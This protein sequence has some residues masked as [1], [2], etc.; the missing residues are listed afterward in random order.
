MS[1]ANLGFFDIPKL[2]PAVD[3]LEQS[4]K[5]AKIATDKAQRLVEANKIE[6]RHWD[7]LARAEQSFQKSLMLL[8]KV[9]PEHKR[10]M[11]EKYNKQLGMLALLASLA[12]IGSTALLHVWVNR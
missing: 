3:K 6:K 2:D 8:D 10:G 7:K 9:Y 4:V 12:L 1:Y 11:A 5:S